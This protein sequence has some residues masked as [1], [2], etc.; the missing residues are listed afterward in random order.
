MKFRYV[1]INYESGKEETVTFDHDASA[2]WI[3]TVLKMMTD[4]GYVVSGASVIEE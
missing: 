2:L 4:H 3:T 1:L